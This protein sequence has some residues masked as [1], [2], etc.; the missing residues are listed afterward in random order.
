MLA[1]TLPDQVYYQA[2][3]NITL[4]KILKKEYE[5]TFVLNLAMPS[6]SSAVGKAAA[7]AGDTI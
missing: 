5:L 2:W 7:R 6:P 4:F 3:K 1:G